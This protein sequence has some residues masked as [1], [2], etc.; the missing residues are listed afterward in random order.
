M[1]R[2]ISWALCRLSVTNVERIAC[3][4]GVL[5][6]SVLRIRRRVVL[7]NLRRALGVSGARGRALG[8]RVCQHFARSALEVLRLP[9]LDAE[10]ARLV[11]GDADLARIET[12]RRRGRGVLV[13][14]AHLGAWDTLACAAARRGLPLNVI[15]RRIKGALV[16]G[17]WMDQRRRC[18]VKLLPATGSAARIREAL[19]RNELVALVLDQHDPAGVVVPF[20]GRPAATS[21]ALA[22]LERMTGAPVLPA[23]LVREEGAPGL[24]LEL[25]AVVE[26]S[27]G[28]SMGE[29]TA[30]YTRIVE[31]AV[32]A[33]PDQWLWLHRRWKV[34]GAEAVAHRA[35]R[36]GAA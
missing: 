7:G 22:R 9:L 12:L 11:I 15:T 33:H 8:R 21:T 16:D 27:S 5:L 19:R 3:C 17:F 30:A 24:R 29:R 18:G 34:H 28:S 6:W 26:L 2:V 32:R 35:S 23:F 25:G 4:I 10:R 13:L 1:L 31:E 20:F 36:S 14:T